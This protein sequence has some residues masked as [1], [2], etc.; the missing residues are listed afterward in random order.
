M[1]TNLVDEIHSERI[2]VRRPTELIGCP[3]TIGGGSY[4]KTTDCM[5]GREGIGEV[6]CTCGCE[7]FPDAM[8]ISRERGVRM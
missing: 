3:D 1:T 6:S 5:D 4:G 2:R 7:T 8:I